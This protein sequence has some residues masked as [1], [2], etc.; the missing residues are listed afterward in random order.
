[1]RPAPRLVS[2]A[3]RTIFQAQS[4]CSGSRRHNAGSAAWWG[5]KPCQTYPFA[6]QILSVATV[7]AS[8]V[9]HSN[10]GRL[11]IILVSCI[12]IG[13]VHLDS[14]G[15]GTSVTGTIKGDEHEQ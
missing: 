13:N 15:T 7:S 4:E 10:N 5:P 1:M 6:S 9:A 8:E 2:R 14:A 3:S 12:R 11:K